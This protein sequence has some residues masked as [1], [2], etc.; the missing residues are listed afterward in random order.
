VGE[1]DPAR[2]GNHADKE[3]HPVHDVHPFEDGVDLHLITALRHTFEHLFYHERFESEEHD[4]P[5]NPYEEHNG[6]KEPLSFEEELVPPSVDEHD[7]T[8]NTD[9]GAVN[10][11][12]RR[13][14]VFDPLKEENL[15]ESLLHLVKGGEDKDGDKC[16][17]PYPEDDGKNMYYQHYGKNHSILLMLL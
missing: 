11:G 4:Y 16:K 13:K 12:E 17:P 10:P 6:K 15:L 2:G 9:C 5:E 14:A 7:N 1:H 8:G 3:E